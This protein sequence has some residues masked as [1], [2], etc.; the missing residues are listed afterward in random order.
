MKQCHYD[1]SISA[2]YR[3]DLSITVT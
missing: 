3:Y 2:L 1:L